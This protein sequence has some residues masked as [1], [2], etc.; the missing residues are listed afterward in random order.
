MQPTNA[1]IVTNGVNKINESHEFGIKIRL[2]YY[3]PMFDSR[4]EKDTD[5]SDVVDLE[6]KDVS[7]GDGN[8]D[9]IY[10][11]EQPTNMKYPRN[12]NL[13]LG[14]GYQTLTENNKNKSVYTID[15]SITLNQDIIDTYGS[16]KVNKIALYGVLLG[17]K[18][19][20]ISNET[21]PSEPFLFGYCIYN[22]PIQIDSGNDS[23]LLDFVIDNNTDSINYDP[24]P[25][26]DEGSYWTLGGDK[27]ISFDGSVYIS[28]TTS[29]NDRRKYIYQGDSKKDSFTKLLS[30]ST[31]DS[32]NLI[33]LG[34]LD[35]DYEKQ[36]TDFRIVTEL[37]NYY[38]ETNNTIY[39]KYDDEYGIGKNNNRWNHLYLLDNVFDMD[40]NE[41]N[42]IKFDGQDKIFT[43]DNIDVYVNSN[44]FGNLK[45]Y[46]DL[47][48]SIDSNK[49][50]RI[51]SIED[52][53]I[54]ST[55]E[56]K[57][58]NSLIPMR[59]NI[60][61]GQSNQGINELYVRSLRNIV[62][63]P[64]NIHNSLIPINV[65]NLGDIFNRWN[66]VY[67]NNIDSDNIK[68]IDMQ[69]GE[70]TISKLSFFNKVDSYVFAI[71]DNNLWDIFILYKIMENSYIVYTTTIDINN[72]L[73]S[74]GIQV[75]I[76]IEN[77]KYIT[78][79]KHKKLQITPTNIQAINI[80][81]EFDWSSNIIVNEDNDDLF[82]VPTQETVTNVNKEELF[83]EKFQ[84]V[85]R[86]LD[87]ILEQENRIHNIGIQLPP[88]EDDEIIY[89]KKLYIR[90]G[91]LHLSGPETTRYD[92]LVCFHRSD[93]D[94]SSILKRFQNSRNDFFGVD[95]TNIP[96]DFIDIGSLIE[97][98][99]INVYLDGAYNMDDLN[100]DQKKGI[101][102][103]NWCLDGT[104]FEIDYYILVNNKE[105][106]VQKR[107][108]VDKIVINNIRWIARSKSKQNRS[109]SLIYSLR[110]FN[111]FIIAKLLEIGVDQNDDLISVLR[112]V[113]TSNDI[114]FE[115]KE[116]SNGSIV[117]YRNRDG[118][119]VVN[120]NDFGRSQ[121]DSTNFGTINMRRLD[122]SSVS[123][124]RPIV[125]QSNVQ[126]SDGSNRTIRG[127]MN[128]EI[129]TRKI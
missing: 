60:D 56:I 104:G 86:N 58:Q 38:L 91:G 121:F 54:K 110:G 5:I 118:G 25:Y 75:E 77:I 6:S 65:D 119:L 85:T 73:I 72:E 26:T 126:Y 88:T 89:V 24:L 111:Y 59:T 9:I 87:A 4:I 31:D 3:L 17:S 76:P 128:W 98:E 101:G 84:I 68:T 125:Y 100:S 16:I 122:G 15:T 20:A 113:T 115:H 71:N 28:K 29:I 67:T 10:W 109:G 51:S 11:R 48:L 27:I 114:I 97:N 94:Q 19:D 41:G 33:S 7:I 40:D 90:D 35:E 23:L 34:F 1:I 32:Y 50:I 12:K 95:F 55:D 22:E 106:I 74:T 14:I 39:P 99:T 64:I 92:S 49:K 79:G 43:L 66:F 63:R 96:T 108:I 124:Y 117:S 52:I 30:S 53:Q 112:G 2:M 18:P 80:V 42:N 13:F 47:D 83:D 127:S 103:S 123:S 82:F 61:L 81:D 70:G 62:N 120:R 102:L 78:G 44:I 45:N 107:T 105:T 21:I 37:D 129:Y 116:H 93:S 57:V 36:R 46:T 8:D 69:L